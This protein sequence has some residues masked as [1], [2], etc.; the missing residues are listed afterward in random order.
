MKATQ[1]NRSHS[2]IREK[3]NSLA[4]KRILAQ[5]NRL[6]WCMQKITRYCLKGSFSA[7]PCQKR[8]IKS[9]LIPWSSRV[10]CIYKGHF[11]ATP[12]TKVLHRPEQ[13]KAQIKDDVRQENLNISKSDYTYITIFCI[14]LAQLFT[15]VIS[16][17]WV[18]YIQRVR[19]ISRIPMRYPQ[20]KTLLPQK[21]PHTESIFSYFSGFNWLNM[22]FVKIWHLTCLMLFQN[23]SR[24]DSESFIHSFYW[25]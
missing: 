23:R 19:A 7:D 16:F 1:C 21:T 5:F 22:F 13:L 10:K 8:H 17:Q 25:C 9:T 14:D 20:W 24:G 18:S 6:W 11:W 4:T 12:V 2:F 3:L 15:K